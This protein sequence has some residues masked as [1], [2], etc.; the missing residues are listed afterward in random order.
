[1]SLI[2]DLCIKMQNG[3]NDTAQSLDLKRTFCIYTDAG[4]MPSVQNDPYEVRDAE[5]RSHTVYGILDADPSRLAPI[6]GLSVITLAGTLE[7]MAEAKLGHSTQGGE[8]VEAQ[9]IERLL[10]AYGQGENGTVYEYEGDGGKTYTVTLNFSPAVLGDW[11]VHSTAFGEVIPVSMSVYLSAVENGV[12]AND[13]K[14]WIDGYPVYYESL[15]LTRQKTVDQYTYKR[16][17][18]IR[19]TV[20]QHGFGVDLTMPVLKSELSFTVM[21]EILRGDFNVPHVV[22]V[23]IPTH[24]VSVEIP[25]HVEPIRFN[26]LCAFGNSSAASQPGKNVG[27][28]VSLVECKMEMAADAAGEGLSLLGQQW[29]DPVEIYCDEGS[30]SAAQ[31][32]ELLGLNKAEN[33]GKL[34]AFIARRKSDEGDLFYG[35]LVYGDKNANAIVIKL[36]KSA[37]LYVRVS[38]GEL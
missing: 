26:Y 37:V 2:N 16:G 19:S 35:S 17:E 4:Q 33:K 9:R 7:V 29:S 30:I 5:T 10:N 21:T 11:Q 36:D 27:A 34:Y 38:D 25:A 3:L 23:E 31:L 14:V 20:L 6:R 15:N 18:S 8:L 13:L 12:S 32:M 1:M 28:T 24:V 22:S